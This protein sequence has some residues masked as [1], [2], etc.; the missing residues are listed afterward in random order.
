MENQCVL[1]SEQ[2]F[3]YTSPEP[4][5]ECTGYVV[6]SHSNYAS[7]LAD[8]SITA[9]D[10]TTSFGYGFAAVIVWGY[11]AAYPVGI[12]KRLIQKL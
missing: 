7:L 4:V 12:A 11:F 5:S 1:I 3:L 6:I 9:A 8:N 2:G 10:L